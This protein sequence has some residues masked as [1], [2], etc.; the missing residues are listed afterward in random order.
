M[1]TYV[2]W[3]V[4]SLYLTVAAFCSA[5]GFTPV[6]FNCSTLQGSQLTNLDQRIE[7]PAYRVF[8]FPPRGENWC[9]KSLASQGLSF[10]KAPVPWQFLDSRRRQMSFSQW[11]TSDSIHGPRSGPSRLWFQYRVTGASEI[12]S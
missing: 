9:V 2:Q 12:R 1:K 6:P 4:G 7:V 10:L 11:H 5:A 3:A 8:G